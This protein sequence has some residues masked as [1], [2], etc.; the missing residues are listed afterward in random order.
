VYLKQIEASGQHLLQLIETMLDFAEVESGKMEFHPAALRLSEVVGDV[1]NMLQAKSETY[2]V[3]IQLDLSPAVEH[4]HLDPMR[5]RQVLLN[6]I[7]NAIKFSH[8]GGTVRVLAR[9][10]DDGLLRIEVHDDGIGI[11]AEQLPGLFTQ[12]HQLSQGANKKFDGTGMGLAV[13]RRLV[14]AQGGQVGVESTLGQ[15]SIF[16]VVL[17]RGG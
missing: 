8:S 5:L 1:V 15:G 2:S 7:G 9:A 16:H 10:Q 11:A 17:P 3:G 6:Y 13:V 12:F 4:I 14:E